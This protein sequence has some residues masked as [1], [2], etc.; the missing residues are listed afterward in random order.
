M[1]SPDITLRLKH[2]ANLQ[3]KGDLQKILLEAVSTI[4]S[5]QNWKELWTEHNIAYNHL[6]TAY[7]AAVFRADPQ[8]KKII[9]YELA[10]Q[11]IA[12]WK[13]KKKAEVLHKINKELKADLR[14]GNTDVAKLPGFYWAPRFRGRRRLVLRSMDRGLEQRDG[15]DS[16]EI[17]VPAL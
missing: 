17:S 15:P 4:E 11:E 12:E 8:G 10:K 14:R 3:R 1:S 13:K 9:Q 5:M 6:Y 2:F 16:Q 7:Q